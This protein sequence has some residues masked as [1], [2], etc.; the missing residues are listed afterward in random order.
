MYVIVD[1]NKVLTTQIYFEGDE[2]LEVRPKDPALVRPLEALSG[3]V[4]R[5]TM[6]FVLPSDTGG[7]DTATSSPAD[8]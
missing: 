1:E 5:V 6:D 7:T 8:R 4:N 2:W 3:D